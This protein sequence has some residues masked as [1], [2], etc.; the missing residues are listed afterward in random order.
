[1]PFTTL[2]VATGLTPGASVLDPVSGRQ[3]V[4]DGLAGATLS[5]I[6]AAT[7][8]TIATLGT[9]PTTTN[10]TQLE[11]SSRGIGHALFIEASTQ[12]STQDPATHDLYIVNSRT[13]GS[14]GAVTA[15]L[16]Q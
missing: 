11:G 10:A 9:F 8:M 2:F 14:L 16:G 15:N 7:N 1:M 4:A 6:D 12:A 5:S 3:F 13:A